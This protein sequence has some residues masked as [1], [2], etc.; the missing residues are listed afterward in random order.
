MKYT[1]AY[2][3]TK[4]LLNRTPGLWVIRSTTNKWDYIKL[5]SS[6]QKRASSF[7]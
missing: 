2:R 5:K 3:H 1:L 4:G 7:K 6:V